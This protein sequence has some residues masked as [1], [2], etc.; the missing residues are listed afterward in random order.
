MPYLLEVPKGTESSTVDNRSRGSRMILVRVMCSVGNE[1]IPFVR[2]S[3]HGWAGV[4]VG[5]DITGAL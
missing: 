4:W 3:L 5:N 2:E 1:C